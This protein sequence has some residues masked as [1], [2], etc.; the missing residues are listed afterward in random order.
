MTDSMRGGVG[1]VRFMSPPGDA[2]E[3]KSQRT[4]GLNKLENQ[5]ITGKAKVFLKKKKKTKEKTK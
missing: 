1:L 2:D 4:T 3:H 5:K